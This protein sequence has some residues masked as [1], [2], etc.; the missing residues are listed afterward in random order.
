MGGTTVRSLKARLAL[1]VLLPTALIALVDLGFSYYSADQVAT[2]VQE[3]LLRGSAQII[4]EQVT[5]VD[6]TYEVSVPPAAFELFANRYRDRVFFSVRTRDGVLVSGDA[7]LGPYRQPLRTEVGQYFLAAVR[8]E[9]V[10]V[11]AFKHA[12]PSAIAGDYAI[13]QIAQSLYGHA[14][15]RNELL[16]ATLRQHLLLLS[17]VSAALFM[18]FRWTLR[19]LI[20]LGDAL[21]A[22]R[23]GSLERIDPHS[24]PRELRPMVTALNDYIA[25]LDSTVTSYSVFVANTAHYLRTSFA[26]VMSQVS[27]GKRDAD[28]APGQR[29]ILDAIQKTV[30]QSTR[31]INQLLV[32][33]SLEKP[34]AAD[35]AP[36]WCN[37]AQVVRTVME[38]L[39]ALAAQQSIA[40]GIDVFDEDLRVAAPVHLLREV[41]SNLVENAIRHMQCSGTVTL[42]VQAAGTEV[43]IEV[44]DTGVGIAATER[45]RVF[46]RF[47]RGA[48]H[49]SSSSGLGLSIVR[50][51]CAALG[52]R[53][54][55]ASPA[56]GSGLVV[57]V[58]LP[59]APAA[60][61]DAA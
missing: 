2:L 23:P 39:A 19:P 9:P 34:A 43:V 55:L 58:T 15:F 6:G 38:E 52:G 37:P 29:E 44:I 27:F 60:P 57:T 20:D 30:L 13:T 17:I 41:V 59:G 47:Y 24:V 5:R 1:W 33:A 53:V 28:L 21:L 8:G 10:R 3:Q 42:S 35:A 49:D 18:A 12:L 36:V 51:I 54:A 61:A 46:E 48:P 25:R 31:T 4:S 56:A 26:I 11:I 45:D 22:R 14:A 16:R 40:L 7:E 32:L 50:E